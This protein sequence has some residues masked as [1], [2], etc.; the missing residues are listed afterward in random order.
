MHLG[1]VGNINDP[2]NVAF[3][4]K[5][6]VA[7]SHQ[8]NLV[9]Q[10]CQVLMVPLMHQKDRLLR[11]FSPRWRRDLLCEIARSLENPNI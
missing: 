4:K 3:T 8:P 2:S 1:W 7:A 11:S 10:N 6:R 5:K 9:T